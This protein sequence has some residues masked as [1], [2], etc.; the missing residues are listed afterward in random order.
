MMKE[1]VTKTIQVDGVEIATEAFGDPS[2]P[3]VLLIMGAMASMLWWPDEFCRQLAGRS[4]YVIRYDHRDT[5][6][7]TTYEPGKPGYTSADMID[8]TV[9]VL[10]GYGLPAAHLVGMSAGGA[11]AQSVAL[12]YPERVLSLTAISTS[13]VGLDTSHLPQAT[14]KYRQHSAEIGEVD[15]SDREQAI[16]SMVKEMRVL[17]SPAHPFDEVSARKFVERDFDRARCFASAANHFLLEEGR[18][19]RHRLPDLRVP[20]LVI[21]GT[22]D[23]L[24]PIQHGEAFAQAVPGAK[25]V[26]LEGGGHEL[27]EAHWPQIIAAITR[28]MGNS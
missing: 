2:H 21:H 3:P 20:L 17:A 15:W 28:H 13:P 27:N 9:R 22:A 12:E 19:R 25:L 14:E 18:E 8:D 5:G 24:L 26:R 23:P 10:D 7:S 11:I 4:C 6:R 16:R 1:A